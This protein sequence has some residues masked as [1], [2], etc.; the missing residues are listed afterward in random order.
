MVQPRN[1]GGGEGKASDVAEQGS[2][3]QKQ[4]CWKTAEETG[5]EMAV[6]DWG[7]EQVTDR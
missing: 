7:P 4:P 2:E 3:R 5:Q 6:R 1:Q